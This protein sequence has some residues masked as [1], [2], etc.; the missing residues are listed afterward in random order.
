M[1]RACA[2][3]G[4]ALASGMDRSGDH[5]ALP[6]CGYQLKKDHVISQT[7]SG[8]DP[9]EHTGPR[10]TRYWEHAAYPRAFDRPLGR[11]LVSSIRRQFLPTALSAGFAA[12][13]GPLDYVELGSF[14]EGGDDWAVGAT[15][16]DVCPR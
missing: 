9:R 6:A 14:W 11:R 1:A 4:V 5:R 15:P 8:S 13:A 16:A 2:A 7:L 12:I 3:A 10:R